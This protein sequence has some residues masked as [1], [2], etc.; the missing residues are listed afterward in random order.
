MTKK[1]K[2]LVTKRPPYFALAGL[3]LALAASPAAHAQ[4]TNNVV[5]VGGTE[6]MRVRVAAAGFTPEQRAAQIQERVN[7]LLGCGTVKPEDITVQQRG[8]DAVVLCK[9]QLLLT[10][11]R[12]T[13]RFNRT[14][15]LL[16]AQ[17]WAERMRR[18]LPSLTQPK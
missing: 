13:A 8:G 10:A 4:A 5:F 14:T 11:D 1:A 17:G 2:N 18:V 7:L 3:A 6:I 12:A 15:P 9:G 16:L